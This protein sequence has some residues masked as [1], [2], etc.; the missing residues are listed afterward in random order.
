[1]ANMSNVLWKK[2][3]DNRQISMA[4]AFRQVLPLARHIDI[5]VGYFFLSGFETIEEEIDEFMIKGG[6]IRVL[7]GNVTTSKTGEVIYEGYAMQAKEQLLEEIKSAKINDYKASMVS[8]LRE[9]I[10]GNKVEVKVYTGDANYF[11][12][13]SYL[14]YR[15]ERTE[16]ND[17]IAIVGS[18]N[19]SRSGFLRNTELNSLSQDNFGAL[20]EWFHEIWD[21]EEVSDFSKELLEFIDTEI[22]RFKDK[23]VYMH[24]E[25]TY[26][27][28]SRYFAKR[29]PQEIEGEFM[30]TLYKHQRIGVAE[31]KYR[32]DEFGTSVLAD[33]VG[34]GK[35][36]T[37]A[38]TLCA[39][40]AKKTIIIAS[41]KLHDQW[42]DEMD[43]VGVLHS[44][45]QLVSKEE[46]A[47]LDV[48]EMTKFVNVD[49]VIVD[50]AHQGLKNHRTKLYRNLS[51]LKEKSLNKIKGLLLTAT[52]WNN[53]RSDVFNLGRLFLR[54]E[55]IPTERPYFPYL[56]HSPRKAAKMI[57]QDDKAF[58]A[59]WRDLFL[60]RTKNTYGGYDVQYADREFPVAEIS[61][62]PQ[63]E[64]ALAANGERINRLYLPYMNPIRYAKSEDEVEFT[65]DRLKILFLKRAD[66]SW[67][68]FKDT[69][70]KVEQRL[71]DLQES[72]KRIKSQKNT[73]NE[74]KEWL[75]E[76]YALSIQEEYEGLF[77]GMDEEELTETLKMEQLSIQK[78][79]KHRIR[80]DNKIQSLSKNIANHML[81]TMLKHAEHDLEI[82]HQIIS[83]LDDAFERKDEKY[84]K[85]R[86]TVYN[87]L[88]SGEKVLLVSQ[89][90]S[91]VLDYY[92]RF[93]QDDKLSPYS[94]AQVSGGSQD[95]YIGTEIQ[96]SKEEILERFSPK[97]KN[98]EEIVG[99]SDEVQLV[100]GT[101]T[102]SVG[103][104]LQDCHVIM[105]LDLPYNPMNLEQRIGRIDRPREEDDEGV[106]EIVTFPSM[107]V[108]ESELQLSTRLKTKLEGIYQDTKF[109]DLIL[110]EYQEFLNE[111]LK[112]RQVSQNNMKEMMRNTGESTIVG[113]EAEEHSAEYLK[114]Q[115]R[116]RKAIEE[117]I[118]L[119][120][121]VHF[122]NFSFTKTRNTDLVLAVN[123]NDVNNVKI[124]EYLMHVTLQ[125]N[126]F[127]TKLTEVE[128]NWH[129]ATK[130]PILYNSE[131][132]RDKAMELIDSVRAYVTDKITKNEV[133]SYNK[134]IS[135]E[136]EI[137]ENLVDKKI[138]RVVSEITDQVRGRNK[139]MIASKINAAG[140]S[141]KSIRALMEN[142]KYIDTRYDEEEMEHI[143]ELYENIDLLWSYYDFYFELFV[144]DNQIEMD[145][146]VKKTVRQADLKNSFI[147]IVVGNITR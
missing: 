119:S 117:N 139:K 147:R 109:D 75:R 89:F 99:T 5:A 14:F 103:Q 67:R 64:K 68:A 35:T 37:A 29:L 50:E 134:R 71:V 15:Q 33:G 136:H 127:L 62:E 23:T 63:K 95:W 72:L 140:Y 1:M 11:H 130:K 38:A 135:I 144:Q 101:E 90:R 132:E 70:L 53:S 94:L 26:L 51:Y 82:L 122:K 57:E 131:L 108:I 88:K 87:Y 41:R 48:N 13:K 125:E 137:G 145:N 69:L 19:F 7:M 27:M 76:Y 60:Q 56:Y 52:P 141:P 59:F 146:V 96:E 93:L 28:F 120:K 104:N 115:K 42:Q 142:I 106:I 92:E 126:S 34:L 31:L 83:E 111:V 86:E 18:S 110:P 17:G 84:E 58:R 107:P 10:A 49:L 61:Y 118:P 85:V 121:D 97:S 129:Q 74:F 36:R 40:K 43:A 133:N 9:W 124:D 12:A 79:E 55:N 77:E 100:I 47:K 112:K 4:D 24:P 21:G 30:D 123:L 138:Q 16:T 81:E 44:D 8:K 113:V 128:N 114:S 91:T 3:I 6:T 54:A 45:Y 66:S 65:A 78:K 102:L 80:L 98:R 105:N 2:V 46:I 143:N 116:M 25:E 20:T 22:P 32:L 73:V 39:V